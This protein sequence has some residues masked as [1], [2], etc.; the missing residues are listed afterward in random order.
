MLHLQAG[1]H[2]Q[3]VEILVLVDQELDRPGVDVIDGLGGLDSHGA[4]LLAQRRRP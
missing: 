4:H 1:V 2:L 3:E